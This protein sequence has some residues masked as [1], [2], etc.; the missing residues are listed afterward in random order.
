M[1]SGFQV[2]DEQGRSTLD[3][4]MRTGRILGAAEL[5]GGYGSITVPAVTG[6]PFVLV[7]DWPSAPYHGQFGDVKP[8]GS[9]WFENSTTIR[10]SIGG[11]FSGQVSGSTYI[12]YGAY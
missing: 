4:T 9:V 2:F 12:Y 3:T 7:T 10:W 5:P 6:T 8:N 11:G 1:A